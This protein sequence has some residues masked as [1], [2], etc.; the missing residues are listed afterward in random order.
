[1]ID[2]AGGW[3]T[4]IDCFLGIPYAKPPVGKLRFQVR[5]TNCV[6][7]YNSH[8]ETSLNVFSHRRLNKTRRP[9]RENYHE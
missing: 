5:Y 8:V 2:Y 1:L 7:A 4:T 6:Q 3:H 9:I